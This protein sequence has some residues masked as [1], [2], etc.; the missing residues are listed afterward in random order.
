MHW[1]GLDGVLLTNFEIYGQAF[2]TVNVLT[3]HFFTVSE[4]IERENCMS[5]QIHIFK[6]I[7]FFKNLQYLI[8]RNYCQTSGTYKILDMICINPSMGILD[9][10]WISNQTGCFKSWFCWNH[11]SMCFEIETIFCHKD[12][13]K[14]VFYLTCFFLCSV[15]W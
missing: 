1:I 6:T 7:I 13:K 14:R 11:W 5:F 4:H 15:V 12:W 10:Q 3:F 9:P 2:E 8:E